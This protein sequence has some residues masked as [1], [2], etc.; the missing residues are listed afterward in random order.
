MHMLFWS[1][2]IGTTISQW[3]WFVFRRLIYNRKSSSLMCT[4]YNGL[5]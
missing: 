5:S 3:F 1:K 2:S 4:S